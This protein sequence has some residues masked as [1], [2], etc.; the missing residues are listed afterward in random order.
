MNK[1]AKIQKRINFEA[2]ISTMDERIHDWI[3]T[4]NKKQKLKFDFSPE[5]LNEL[6]IYLTNKFNLEDLSAQQNKFEIDACMSYVLKVFQTNL[7]TKQFSIELDDDRNVLYNRPS[8]NTK[9]KVGMDFSPYYF[10]PSII[11]LKRVGD[12]KKQL[13][14]K[15]S[16][17]NQEYGKL[18]ND[19]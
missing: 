4:L 17:Y 10:L 3:L 15:Q 12:F 7:E 13:H 11:N 5:S 16:K 2:W 9:P 1:E 14:L 8:I 19:H 18:N 6:E